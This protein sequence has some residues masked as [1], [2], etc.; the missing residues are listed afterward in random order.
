M[1]RPDP[2]PSE[3]ASTRSLNPFRRRL[4]LAGLSLVA[5]MLSGTSAQDIGDRR[6]REPGASRRDLEF[7]PSD[8]KLSWAPP[9]L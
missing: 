8:P 4:L 7:D 5:M 9:V 6:R 3:K 2:H 1:A